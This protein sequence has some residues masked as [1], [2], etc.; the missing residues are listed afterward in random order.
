MISDVAFVKINSGLPQFFTLPVLYI[1]W[2]KIAK[3]YFETS[4]KICQL[5]CG[6]MVIAC[7]GW[8]SYKMCLINGHHLLSRTPHNNRFPSRPNWFTL[9]VF[10][11][12]RSPDLLFHVLIEHEDHLRALPGHSGQICCLSYCTFLA[13]CSLHS[14]HSLFFECLGNLVCLID[15]NVLM[16]LIPCCPMSSLFDQSHMY[17]CGHTSLHCLYPPSR[18]PPN[19]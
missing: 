18:G 14:S 10:C 3:D 17:M 11:S 6:C 8:L 7:T 4:H 1:A 15:N 16:H 9:M 19:T 13:T 12:H 2:W 5:H